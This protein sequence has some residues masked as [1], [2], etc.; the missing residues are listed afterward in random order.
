MLVTCQCN[1]TATL[2]VMKYRQYTHIHTYTHTY[3]HT[4]YAYCKAVKMA[5]V[6]FL[7]ERKEGENK[8]E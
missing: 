8:L 4:Y 1:V 5:F 6:R 7:G 2:T 3:I